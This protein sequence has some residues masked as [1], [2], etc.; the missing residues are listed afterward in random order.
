MPS[1]E[2]HSEASGR[3]EFEDKKNRF[4]MVDEV[5]SG[6]DSTVVRL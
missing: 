2:E 3:F 1:L 4:E 6:K 5:M